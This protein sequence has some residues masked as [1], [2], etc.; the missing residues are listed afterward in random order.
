MRH[1]KT[2]LAVLG[3]VTILVLAG[4]SIA[5]AATGKAFL[6][7]KGNS[8]NKMTVLKRTTAGPALKLQT[9]SS[10]AAPLAV[11]G[12]GRVGNLNADLLDGMDSTALSNRV[13]R[14]TAT[15]PLASPVSTFTKSLPLAPGVYEVSFNAYLAGYAGNNYAEC[16]IRTLSGGT[17]T[18][19]SADLGMTVG[20]GAPALNASGVVVKTASNTV[21]FACTTSGGTFYTADV[22]PFEILAKKVDG[23]TSSS[24]R[25][26]PSGARV[27]R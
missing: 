23:F 22:E 10:S 26:A 15:V 3:A 11:T 12:R 6:L 5:M 25:T 17:V 16:F 7:G 1:L 13:R 4:N 8:A 19:Y 20:S 24:L 21:Q 14:F 27:A 2:S 9:T 18:S